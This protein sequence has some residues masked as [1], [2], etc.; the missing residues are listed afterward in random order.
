MNNLKSINRYAKKVIPKLNLSHW[1][2]N[3]I[4][5]EDEN[6]ACCCPEFQ[7][8]KATIFIGDEFLD[9][10]EKDYKQVTV[11]HE[12]LHCHFGFID[13]LEPPKLTEMFLE[14]SVELLARSL[15]K[16]LKI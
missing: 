13:F 10:D 11:V 12:L 4:Y 2:I 5:D 14:E 3:F 9:S 1:E 16:E 15:H 8:K 6:W 7:Y